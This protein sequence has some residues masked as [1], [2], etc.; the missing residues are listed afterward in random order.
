MKV[1]G[2]CELS[3]KGQEAVLEE[4]SG[5]LAWWMLSWLFLQEEA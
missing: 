2:V 4:M 1:H 3:S 5:C